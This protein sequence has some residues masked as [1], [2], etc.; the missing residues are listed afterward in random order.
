MNFLSADTMCGLILALFKRGE[1]PKWSFSCAYHILCYVIGTR[2]PCFLLPWP[3][4][5]NFPFGRREVRHGDKFGLAGQTMLSTN[6]HRDGVP[7]LSCELTYRH[8]TTHFQS[9]KLS[10]HGGSNKTA[11]CN[12]ILDYVANS[13]KQ[14]V[15]STSKYL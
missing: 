1:E 11:V 10:S 2:S 12:F 3:T 15:N 8:T 13:F 4:R 7:Y 14:K 6:P 9:I 5:P